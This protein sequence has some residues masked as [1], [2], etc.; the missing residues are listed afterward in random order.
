MK[1][2]FKEVSGYYGIYEVSNLGNVRSMKRWAT[3][4]NGFRVV[5]ERILK[6]SLSSSGY[7]MVGLTVKGKTVTRLI[8]T[9]MSES[10]LGHTTNRTT[11]CDHVDNNKLNNNLENLQILTN[12][13]NLLKYHAYNRELLKQNQ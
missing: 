13:E 11:V 1:E 6:P 8:H 5:N 4:R 3:N 2:R 9:L 10:F 7:W 12:Q